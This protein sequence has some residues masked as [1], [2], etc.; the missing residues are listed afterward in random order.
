M[1]PEYPAELLRKTGSLVNVVKTI[2]LTC[3]M[4]VRT[5]LQMHAKCKRQ[6]SQLSGKYRKLS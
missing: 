2:A 6:T 1:S 3:K 5:L 4:I